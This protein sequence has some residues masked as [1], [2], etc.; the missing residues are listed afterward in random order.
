LLFIGWTQVHAILAI[1]DAITS[2]IDAIHS[3]IG[4]I[5]KIMDAIPQPGAWGSAPKTNF[6][7]HKQ[8]QR[9]NDLFLSTP[10][11]QSEPGLIEIAH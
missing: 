2:I 3:I 7:L 10:W 11:P 1:I 8:V 9:Q 4:A 6:P 5:P